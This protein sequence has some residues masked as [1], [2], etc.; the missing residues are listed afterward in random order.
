MV[1]SASPDSDVRPVLLAALAQILQLGML[2]ASEAGRAKHY[3]RIVLHGLSPPSI[4]FQVLM[5]LVPSEE[6]A[7]SRR[8]P[9]AH[10]QG[11]GVVAEAY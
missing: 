3:S 7:Q 5:M 2:H 6:Y 1:A 11:N 9:A 4:G 10:N 8:N